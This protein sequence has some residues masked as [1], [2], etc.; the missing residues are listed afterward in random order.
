MEVY[1]NFAASC[2]EIGKRNPLIKK[3]K[4]FQGSF[5]VLPS[6]HKFKQMIWSNIGFSKWLGQEKVSVILWYSLQLPAF[7]WCGVFV[8]KF[9]RAKNE[10]KEKSA[11]FLIKGDSGSTQICPLTVTQWKI[12]GVRSHKLPQSMNKT[13][14]C[15]CMFSSI[16]VY[17]YRA[18]FHGGIS[19][20][21]A[22]LPSV[23]YEESEWLS[24]STQ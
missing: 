3:Q 22:S 11:I 5:S 10:K 4:P 19:T 8:L 2:F 21:P 15:L 16:P 7:F 18:G 17:H 24:L 23:Q 1:I 14:G 9:W 20:I 6:C 12:A 13:C